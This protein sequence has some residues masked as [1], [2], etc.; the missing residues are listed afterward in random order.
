MAEMSHKQS[1]MTPL[2]KWAGGKTQFITKVLS[3]FPE[4]TEEQT[5]IE[6][7]LGGGSVFLA[8][9]PPRAIV[10]DIN[11][12]LIN[13]YRTLRDDVDNL[14]ERVATLC[15]ES[16]NEEDFFRYRAV[17]NCHTGSQLEEAALFYYLNKACFRGLYRENSKGDFNVPFGNYKSLNV[18]E[19]QFRL[20]STYLGG[21]GIQIECGPYEG[22]LQRAER[23]DFVYLDPPYYP[24]KASQFTKYSASDFSPANHDDLAK[25]V[26]NLPCSFLLSNSPHPSVVEM[27]DGFEYEIFAARR[28]INVNQ[29]KDAAA[30]NELL[31]WN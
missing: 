27:Y 28:A 23:G 16:N 22:V 20:I 25:A 31:V 8:A 9:A 11:P 30:N 4:L 10:N 14:I 21:D 7:F 26:K 15:R 18:N 13:F 17:Y 29:G 24:Q 5:Y 2:L 19:H 3:H 12:H 1:G 6:P